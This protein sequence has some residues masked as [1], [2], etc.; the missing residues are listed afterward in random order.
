MMSSGDARQRSAAALLLA[1]L[2]GACS[3]G[4]SE[5][6]A[7][8][9]E[10]PPAGD[11]SGL[12]GEGGDTT[13]VIPL[14]E[15]GSPY[16]YT[17]GVA[18]LPPERSG[19]AERP[20]PDR[21]G[22]GLPNAIDRAPD[23]PAAIAD[24][25][26][27]LVLVHA[28]SRIEGRLV[29]RALHAD[30]TIV[31]EIGGDA[32]ADEHPHAILFGGDAS[33]T[34]E[35]V[36]IGGGRYELLDTA[37]D[38]PVE[39][40]AVA[41]ST[42]QTRPMA[43]EYRVP[44]APWIAG[45]VT[46]RRGQTARV[47]GLH[48]ADRELWLGDTLLPM[49]AGAETWVDVSIPMDADSGLLEL[50]T[51]ESQQQVPVRVER[52]VQV[53][54]SPLWAERFQTLVHFSSD[55]DLAY[56]SGDR[57]VSLWVDTSVPDTVRF[58]VLDAAADKAL[59]GRE[60]TVWP[61][62]DK[63]VLEAE[64]AALSL[65]WQSRRAWA[66]P[67]RDW[68]AFRSDVLAALNADEAVLGAIEDAVI[69]GASADSLAALAGLRTLAQDALR[70]PAQ[71][72][73]VAT[74]GISQGEALGQRVNYVAPNG[75]LGPNSHYAL[76]SVGSVLD[77]CAG[78]GGRPKSF[79]P[80]DLCMVS[81]SELASSVAVRRNGELLRN[82]I[83][84]SR[85]IFGA[86]IVGGTG[87]FFNLEFGSDQGFIAFKRPF[88]YLEASDTNKTPLCGI[89][90]CQVEIIT[91]G[92]GVGLP[93]PAMTP[94]EKRVFE[95][96]RNRAL[97]DLIVLPVLST[98]SGELVDSQSLQCVS[99]KAFELFGGSQSLAEFY[100]KASGAKKPDGSTDHAALAKEIRTYFTGLLTQ[101]LK[102]RTL[103]D[104]Y[105]T[106]PQEVIEDLLDRAADEASQRLL[107]VIQ[108]AV[109]TT[110]TAVQFATT[111]R[112]IVFKAEPVMRIDAVR[113]RYDATAADASNSIEIEGSAIAEDQSPATE[114]YP[115][116]RLE[117]RSGP[118]SFVAV[119]TPLDQSNYTGGVPAENRF[120]RLSGAPLR[121]IIESDGMFVP[122]T[123][124]VSLVY[125]LDNP[126]NFD[127]A[128]V[129]IEAG[130]YEILGAPR[131][132][133]FAE[134]SSPTSGGSRVF[135]V[136][137]RLN[138][139][140]L[141]GASVELASS[142]QGEIVRDLELIRYDEPDVPETRQYEISFGVPQLPSG[143]NATEFDATLV[144]ASGRIAL[145]KLLV[146]RPQVFGSATVSDSGACQ[147]DQAEVRL[148][149]ANGGY[150]TL[151]TASAPEV[152]A[153]VSGPDD[154]AASL[155]WNNS[156]LAANNR[157]AGVEVTCTDVGD[158]CRDD[159]GE[160]A[161][162]VCTLGIVFDD[163]T[164]V[165]GSQTRFFSLKK[166]DRRVF[167]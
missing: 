107:A 88:A 96:L 92:F 99:N 95:L 71:A 46:A 76:F 146:V 118:N 49:V 125:T 93:T 102:F 54:A 24:D 32:L 30:A 164:S 58:Q 81:S 50:R 27:R 51:D 98:L 120:L 111:P 104:C 144:L 79:R 119:D 130:Q 68:Q 57:P 18:V 112:K 40:V 48:L 136:G 74:P 148:V 66:L 83:A 131:V 19:S 106:K 128:E 147:D 29:D 127:S 15:P 135:L 80:S 137:Y 115:K 61:D 151:D 8:V 69:S 22:D 149:T 53:V 64:S 139:L 155:L 89:E 34:A 26:A 122:S 126:E 153:P 140:D 82:H 10:P 25:E 138:G 94:A 117:G 113:G 123:L 84:V 159:G 97:V 133:G 154:V 114:F 158:D 9:S 31:F 134:G 73:M 142:A 141:S 150:V 167:P 103:G 85:G 78:L 65:A 36:E 21:D 86:D 105:Q 42:W 90:P 28:G 62:Q 33:R 67:Q 6:D 60:V 20:D 55:D 72:K 152:M 77:L 121:T 38:H 124:D 52:Q 75:S 23:I 91:G 63:V 162:G 47:V 12:A 145:G 44:G 70:A 109:E 11:G 7:A 4:G 166:N 56:L 160:E 129:E 35:L 16:F 13:G 3:G 45:A 43:I 108:I 143:R 5:T 100:Q 87:G 1:L 17:D 116:L 161:T 39:A 2:L 37:S 132:D 157:V 14:G 59:V 101:L 163:D 156:Q 41:T 110:I 165:P